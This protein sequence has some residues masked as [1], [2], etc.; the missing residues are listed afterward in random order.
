[1]SIESVCLQAW[2]LG[3]GES[4]LPEVQKSAT[5][6]GAR[7]VYGSGA[8]VGA[9]LEAITEEHTPDVQPSRVKR[10]VCSILELRPIAAKFASDARAMKSYNSS[11][12]A[13]L[14]G[15]FLRREVTERNVPI[16]VQPV[17][18]QYVNPGTI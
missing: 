5:D 8:S 7:Q 4:C 12:E 10:C 11:K 3:V 2:P 14:L 6:V 18:V 16:D 13:L 17:A 9:G 15:T 1:M